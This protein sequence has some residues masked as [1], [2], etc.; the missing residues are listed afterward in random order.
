MVLISN[1]AK[2][3]LFITSTRFGRQ[4]SSGPSKFSPWSCKSGVQPS[5]SRTPLTLIATHSISIT[6]WVILGGNVSRVSDPGAN[7]RNAF[8][9]TTTSGN[10]LSIALVNV[11]FSYTG[12][13]NA[14]SVVN[15]VKNPIPTIKR[16]GAASIAVV[17]VL[18]MFCNIAYFAAGSTTPSLGSTWPMLTESDGSSKTRVRPI[19]RDCSFGVFRLRDWHWWSTGSAQ[20]ACVDKQ[21]RESDGSAHWAIQ[22]DSR[23]RTV[24]SP[25]PSGLP[26][27]SMLTTN[28]RQGVLPWTKFW[29]STK[30]FG[31]PIGP[32]FLKWVMTFIMIVAPPAGDA[33][34]FGESWQATPDSS[35]HVDLQLITCHAVVSL[36]T[37]PDGLFSLAMAIGLYI[38]RYRHKR[39]GHGKTEF[40]AWDV[41]VVFFVLVQVYI[42]ATPWIPPEG[43]AYS[44]EVSFWYA[45]YCVVGIAM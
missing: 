37:Y 18:Y 45:T 14:F 42:I 21:L 7:F 24:G 10:Q 29:V 31:T 8:E 26:L 28:R 41:F 1:P 33:F 22:N 4:I 20:R 44:G 32:Y 16:H 13:T 9:G 19:Q 2:A 25:I 17:A 11:I 34:Q 35:V 15:E 30:P 3:S 6:G 23:G 39:L 27:G 38:I 12:Y 36:K 40:K 5:S 43:G